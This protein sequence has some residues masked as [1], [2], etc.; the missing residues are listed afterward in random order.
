[1]FVT[2]DLP[3]IDAANCS[4]FIYIAWDSHDQSL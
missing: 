1:M 3:Y 4:T 2:V